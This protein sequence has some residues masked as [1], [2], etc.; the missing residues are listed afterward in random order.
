MSG[1]SGSLF[2]VVVVIVLMIIMMMIIML[3]TVF[4]SGSTAIRID[5]DGWKASS[6]SPSFRVFLS[7]LW[8]LVQ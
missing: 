2:K 7:F 6:F 3:M 5:Y 4:G 1:L 8:L